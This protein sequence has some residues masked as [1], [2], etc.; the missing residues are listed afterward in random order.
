VGLWDQIRDALSIAW[1]DWQSPREDERNRLITGLTEAWRAEEDLSRQIRR[2]IPE[3]PYEQFRRR[4]DVMARKDEQHS[5]LIQESLKTLGGVLREAPKALG[6]SENT[7]LSGPWHCSQQVL[8]EKREFYERYRQEAN[9]V[10][11]ASLQ[12]LL[13]RLRDDEDRHQDELIGILI[14]LDAHIYETI[15]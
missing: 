5:T 12:S 8:R 2:I 15:N 11:D 14:H 1:A 13:K 9:V 10:D 7:F 4:L 3:I 6:G